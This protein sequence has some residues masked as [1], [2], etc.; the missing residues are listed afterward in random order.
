MIFLSLF[1]FLKKLSENLFYNN[2]VLNFYFILKKNNFYEYQ[3]QKHNFL[4]SCFLIR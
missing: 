1:K 3:I 2:T 4:N